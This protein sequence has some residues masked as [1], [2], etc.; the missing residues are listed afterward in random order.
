MRT[1]DPRSSIPRA[2]SAV[3]RSQPQGNEID[4][5]TRQ[6]ASPCAPGRWNFTRTAGTLFFLAA[7]GAAAHADGAL[8]RA[9]V[10][11]ELAEAIRTGDMLAPGESGLT[12]RELDPQRYPAPVVAAGKTRAQ[13]NA[14]LADAIRTGNIMTS[15]ETG[16]KLNEEYPQ[17]YPA[18]VAVAGKTRAQVKVELAE[19]I[20]TGDMFAHDESGLRLN[21]EYPQRYAKARAMNGDRLRLAATPAPSATGGTT[22]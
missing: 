20:R 18:P 16:L 8:S 14:E 13:V 21:E 15:D 3:A 12:F 9:Q 7:L 6:R 19:A 5:Q 10:K 2:G 11:A 22:Q 4:P 1:F 17:R